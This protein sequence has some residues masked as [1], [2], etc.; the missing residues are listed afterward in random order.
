MISPLVFAILRLFYMNIKTLHRLFFFF[1]QTTDA[2]SLVMKALPA[3]PAG[4][5]A[6]ILLPI[7]EHAYACQWNSPSMY[8][9]CFS[10][11]HK[12]QIPPVWTQ[13][14]QRSLSGQL[15]VGVNILIAAIPIENI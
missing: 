6:A 5:L 14:R 12:R 4:E 3:L 2:R 8:V 7:Q 9:D 1:K 10:T 15:S 13:F 11:A